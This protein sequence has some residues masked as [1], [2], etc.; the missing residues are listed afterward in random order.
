M[1]EGAAL[2]GIEVI[3]CSRHFTRRNALDGLDKEAVR[4]TRKILKG[5]R[6]IAPSAE[7]VFGHDGVHFGR[8]TEQSI[9]NGPTAV[10]TLV[11]AAEGAP[12]M[13]ISR[14]EVTRAA[15]AFIGQTHE[16]IDDGQVV[17]G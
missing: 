7:C 1:N 2:K 8:R 6:R 4:A 15:G 14:Q 17:L 13:W 9:G 11:A 10:P 3:D 16:A 5:G 12:E